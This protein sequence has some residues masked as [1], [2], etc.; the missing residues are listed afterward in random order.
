MTATTLTYT[1]GDESVTVPAGASFALVRMWGAGGGSNGAGYGAGDAARGGPGGFLKFKIPVT[2]SETLTAKVGQGG[3]KGASTRAPGNGGGRTQIA[4]GATILGIAG[5]GGGAG[6]YGASNAQS[7]GGKGGGTT[8]GSGQDGSTNSGSAAPGIGGTQ[9]AGGAAGTPGSPSSGASLQGGNGDTGGGLKAANWPN[10]G[11]AS[12]SGEYGGGGGDGYFGGG[13]GGGSGSWGNGGGGGSSYADASA[14]D[15]V[16]TQGT[17]TTAPGT[18]ESGYVSGVAVG[19]VDSSNGGNGLIYIEWVITST[20]S[21][22]VY[23]STGTPVAR[24]VRAYNRATGELLGETESDDTTGVYSFDVEVAA[25]T[26]VQIVCLDDD[27]GTLEND[28]ILRT[29]T[30]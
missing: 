8:A 29:L 11:R 5:A 19:G 21:G 24:T 23:D 22:T 9:S 12:T 25:D 28:L 15:V 27:E 1:G 13:G 7:F 20:V 4:R 3:T 10:G 16:H 14:T 6:G 2:A 18:S 26:E 30:V 17:T